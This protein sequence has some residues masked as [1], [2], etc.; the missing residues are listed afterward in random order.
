[1]DAIIFTTTTCRSRL[2]N[3]I[4]TVHAKNNQLLLL[5]PHLSFENEK[6]FI[7]S[8]VDADLHW[9]TFE[10]F[11]SYQEMVFCD[12]HADELIINKH[13]TRDGL[14]DCYFEKIKELKNYK[15]IENL[16]SQYSIDACYLLA[17][18][19]GIS[20]KPWES[21]G[22]V[23]LSNLDIIPSRNI[24]KQFIFSI[25][26]KF[27]RFAQGNITAL[28]YG[29]TT[30]LFVG[31]Y[32]RVSSFIDSQNVRPIELTLL[33]YSFLAIILFLSRSKVGAF[34]KPI[35]K[36]FFSLLISQIFSEPIAFLTSVH[37]YSDGLASSSHYLSC[38]LYCL[39]DG[40]IP[41]NYSSRL[42]R[43]F[44]NI[45]C[46]F[47]WDSVSQ[48]LFKDQGIASIIWEGFGK[49]DLPIP[50]ERTLDPN[51]I[52]LYLASGAGDWT[53][54][55]N[56]SDEDFGFLA[57]YELA[58]RH[59]D[60]KFVFRPHPVWLHPSHQGKNSVQRLLDFYSYS[61]LSNFYISLPTKN[62][63]TNPSYN[64]YANASKSLSSLI[65]Q[66]VIVIGDHTDLLIS[67][68]QVGKYVTS[69]NVAKRKSFFSGYSKVGLSLQSSI[70][71]LCT[72]IDGIYNSSYYREC[73]L[74]SIRHY[75]SELGFD[76]G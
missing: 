16:Y 22:C 6:L 8:Q 68:A 27:T 18:D 11:L 53:A 38:D 66:S 31:K 69:F 65:D 21:K 47:V 26:N 46:Y 48:N 35:F 14:I 36:K 62:A 49:R 71:E 7:E 17:H 28:S 3:V 2:L 74:S 39:Q 50:S 59:P 30:Y 40:L 73:Y 4:K 9:R 61:P 63:I 72:F 24:Y 25:R 57:F 55:K 37:N 10:D 29:G 43:Y 20:L 5:T 58:R 54:L 15:I 34:V 32:T 1:M 44:K 23:D 75:N 12:Q 67:C 70:D 60:K 41:A 45:K 52:I 56:R 33:H 42:Y 51:K 19:L 76:R 13:G 64:H